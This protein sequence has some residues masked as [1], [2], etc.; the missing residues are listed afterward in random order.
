MCLTPYILPNSTARR[1]IPMSQAVNLVHPSTRSF[2]FEYFEDGRVS[3]S[4][5]LVRKELSRDY[6]VTRDGSRIPLYITVPCGRCAH[7]AYTRKREFERRLLIEASVSK[8]MF[9]FTLTYDDAHLPSEGL[10]KQHVS[11]FLKRFRR[12]LDILFSGSERVRF[13]CVYNGEYGQ[14]ERYTMRP[15][16][17]GLLFFEHPLSKHDILSISRVFNDIHYRFSRSYIRKYSPTTKYFKIWPYGYRRDFQECT[18]RMASARYLAKYISKPQLIPSKYIAP[19]FFETPRKCGLGTYNIDGLI[20]SIKNSTDGRIYLNFD[21]KLTRIKIPNFV[22]DKVFPRYKLHKDLRSC[23]CIAMMCIRRL[24][25]LSEKDVFI[26]INL[27]SHFSAVVS[28]QYDL[29]SFS[30]DRGRSSFVAKIAAPA[31]ASATR[32]DLFSFLAAYVHQ[33]GKF[34]VDSFYNDLDARLK[35]KSI[36]NLNSLPLDSLDLLFAKLDTFERDINKHTYKHL[37]LSLQ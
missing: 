11:Q 31:V 17:H 36:I 28:Q 24:H 37:N 20:D 2:P 18:N 13:R 25:E 4:I 15:H 34:D 12:R 35:Y 22:I 9:F 32:E 21:G 10:C 7:C 6:V 33:F 23:T 5:D 16:Y 14:D 1:Y 27:I 3:S 8:H 26:N 30:K 19:M 29:L